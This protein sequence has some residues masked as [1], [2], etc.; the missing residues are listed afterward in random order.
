M[1]EEPDRGCLSPICPLGPTV[2]AVVARMGGKKTLQK[3][4]ELSQDAVGYRH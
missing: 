3:G 2:D 1:P 4:G